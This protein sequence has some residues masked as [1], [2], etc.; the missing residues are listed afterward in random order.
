MGIQALTINMWI[1]VW[2]CVCAVYTKQFISS[3]MHFFSLP[4]AA[5]WAR[6]THTCTCTHSHTQLC[7]NEKTLCVP[8]R[9]K[10]G[11]TL[12][13]LL[14][15]LAYCDAPR[16]PNHHCSADQNPYLM[17]CAL[18]G[19]PWGHVRSQRSS[20]TLMRQPRLALGSYE[21]GCEGLRL[22]CLAWGLTVV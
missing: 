1:S 9:C 22:M 20:C 12:L 7:Y 11:A 16:T 5:R 8:A 14:P 17:P 3:A 2:M 4:R 19:T 15:H 10:Y 21:G 18:F 6:I 13:C